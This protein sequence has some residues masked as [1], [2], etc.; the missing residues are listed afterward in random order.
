MARMTQR[1]RNHD[2]TK[3]ILMRRHRQMAWFLYFTKGALVNF[4]HALNT[5]S[6]C[7]TGKDIKEVKELMRAQQQIVDRL[8]RLVSGETT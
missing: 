5:N 6:F 8:G 4:D 7:M 2:A 3:S 1:N